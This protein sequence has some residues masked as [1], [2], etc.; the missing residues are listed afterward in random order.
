MLTKKI[1][2]SAV[3]EGSVRKLADEKGLYLYISKVGGKSWRYDF[4]FAGKRFTLTFGKYPELGLDD[5]RRKHL[6]A[7]TKIANGVN[8]AEEKLAQ[9]RLVR[10]ESGA[11][12]FARVA[13]VWFRSKVDR[14]S[15][16]WEQANKLYLSR[17]L[18]PSI[19]DCALE[20]ITADLLLDVLEQVEKRSGVKT[21]DRVRQTCVQV[22]DYGMRKR[23]VSAMS[24]GRSSAG[25]KFQ[26]KSIGHG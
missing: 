11:S 4:R 19:G 5:A 22:L 20:N 7:R 25:P 21:A 24:Q 14:R 10:R 16:A 15:T 8:P 9:K 1:V 13:D 17:D 26:E 18:N 6:E 23:I 12:A 2:Q 3:S